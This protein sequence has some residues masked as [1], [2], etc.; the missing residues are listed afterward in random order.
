MSDRTLAVLIGLIAGM[1][2]CCC[3]G[4]LLIAA[5]SSGTAVDVAQSPAPTDAGIRADI[6]E[7]YLNRTFM[8]NA[9]GYPSPWPLKAGRLDV[10]P[11]NQMKFIVQVESPLGLMTVNGL[12]TLTARDGELVIRIADVRLGQ[13]PVTA[14]MQAFQPDMEAQINEQANQQLRERTQMAQVKLL[15]VT[16][17]DTQFQFFL[18][19][20]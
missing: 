6:A 12:A 19:S 5:G 15:A 18:A 3:S 7:S 4:G 2:V 20:E 9:A 16:S 10:L 14:L 11:G 13:L 1:L 8:D 17:D